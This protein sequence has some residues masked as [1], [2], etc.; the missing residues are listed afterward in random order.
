MALSWWAAALVSALFVLVVPAGHVPAGV[1][2]G[3]SVRE[4]RWAGLASRL[5]ER[6]HGRRGWS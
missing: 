6:R 2:R 1:A 5:T 3:R 4:M